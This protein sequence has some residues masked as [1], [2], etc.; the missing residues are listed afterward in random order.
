M[1]YVRQWSFFTSLICIKVSFFIL[2]WTIFRPFRLLRYGVMAGGVIVPV[3]Y[4]AFLLANMIDGTPRSGE[5]WFNS[6]VRCKICF[7]IMVPVTAW[8]VVS[9]T[10]ILIL[11]IF[12]IMRLQLSLKEKVGV[13]MLFMTGLG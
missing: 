6:V 12:G 4:L 3:V 13:L 8:G 1:T 7:N 9:D 10:Y 2:Y 5:T 11:P